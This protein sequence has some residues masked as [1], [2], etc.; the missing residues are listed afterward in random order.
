MLFGVLRDIA[1]DTQAKKDCQDCVFQQASVYR[2]IAERTRLIPRSAM[3]LNSSSI[4][5]S[6]PTA[7][8][9]DRPISPD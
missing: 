6:N 9:K 1:K 3:R 2:G 8:Q 4:C 5:L 7:E